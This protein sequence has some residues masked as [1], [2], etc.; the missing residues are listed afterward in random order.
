MQ[1]S[2]SERYMWCLHCFGMEVGF[3]RRLV[4]ERHSKEWEKK[5]H[6]RVCVLSHKQTLLEIF[7]RGLWM[8]QSLTCLLHI[9]SA[10][11]AFGRSWPAWEYAELRNIANQWKRRKICLKLDKPLVVRDPYF[12]MWFN[13]KVMASLDRIGIWSVSNYLIHSKRWR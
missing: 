5:W 8:T 10:S 9:C 6:L 7:Q 13:G 3:K 12:L 11:I 1:N 2:K 4:F